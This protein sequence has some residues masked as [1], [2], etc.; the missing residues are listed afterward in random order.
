M[1]ANVAGAEICY[2]APHG[3][4]LAIRSDVIDDTCPG[5]EGGTSDRR[6]HRVDRN[7]HFKLCSQRFDD[8]NH[9]PE[10]FGFRDRLGTRA[11]GFTPDIYD[12]CTFLFQPESAGDGTFGSKALTPI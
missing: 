10:F 12:F 6:F 8:W 1:H 11:G 9:T 3:F 7:R 2:N 4:I 5:L